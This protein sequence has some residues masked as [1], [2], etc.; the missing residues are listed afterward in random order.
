MLSRRLILAAP[1]LAAT[2]SFARAR[3]HDFDVIVIGAGLSG[4]TAATTAQSQGARTLVLEARPRIGGRMFTLDH[5]PGQP[6]AGAN[7]FSDGYGAALTA[8]AEA[9][10]TMEDI[11]PKLRRSPPMSLVING[12]TISREDWPTHPLNPLP[13]RFAQAFP[14]E[15]G[16]MAMSTHPLVQSPDAWLNPDGPD[17]S[18]GDWLKSQG[19]SEA[20]IRLAWDTSPAY[21]NSAA[22][23]SARHIAFIL[24]WLARQRG[25]GTAQ[26]AVKGGNQRLP[27]GLAARLAEPVRLDT[28]VRAVTQTRTGVTL[29]TSTGATLTAARVILTAPLPALRHIHFDPPL[30]PQKREAITSLPYQAISII[31]LAARTPFWLNDGQSPNMWTDSS[32]GWVLA[33]PF[34]EDPAQPI[35]GLAIHGRGPL[36]RRWKTQGPDNAMA[37]TI[38]AIEGLRP[39]AKGQLSAL[40]Y[41]AWADDPLSGGA[42]AIHAPGQ[43]QRLGPH[44]ATPEGRL[45]FAGEHCSPD[46]RGMEAAAST[47]IMAA[48]AAVG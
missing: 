47:G 1:L 12:Q 19:F 30:S 37:S 46:Q 35:N 18:V 3:R 25:M 29:T 41:Q 9:G 26:Y 40:H 8:A 27:E 34:G 21:G 36:A 33:S 10:V 23:A 5:L 39:A 22:T 44:L 13:G 43:P 17:G 48:L 24:G 42:W 15:A 32:A 14:A 45:H 4:L 28:P 31:F 11:T 38:A 6:E 7:T 16:A 2:P 20:A